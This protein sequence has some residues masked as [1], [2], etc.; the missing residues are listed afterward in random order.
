MRYV[1]VRC[2]RMGPM[3]FVWLLLCT[4]P[5]LLGSRISLMGDDMLIESPSVDQL[6]FL[7]LQEGG[8]QKIFF[9]IVDGRFRK[10]QVISKD[11]TLIEALRSF[12]SPP[13]TRSYYDYFMYPNGTFDEKVKVIH[14]SNPKLHHVYLLMVSFRLSFVKRMGVKHDRQSTIRLTNVPDRVQ[15]ILILMASA[16]PRTFLSLIEDYFKPDIQA[17]LLS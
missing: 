16:S 4:V 11:R 10:I 7:L 14:I 6:A 3:I 12:D 17:I 15:N 9:D 1:C 5:A 13:S 2:G 8:L